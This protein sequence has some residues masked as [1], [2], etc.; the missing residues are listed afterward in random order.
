MPPHT[1]FLSRAHGVQTTTATTAFGHP[2]PACAASQCISH[3]LDCGARVLV[4]D[5]ER[6]LFSMC[7]FIKVHARVA[8]R[9]PR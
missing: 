5:C 1:A 9:S 4:Q 3:K 2:P 7:D 6:R 8:C